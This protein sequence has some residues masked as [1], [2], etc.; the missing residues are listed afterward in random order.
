MAIQLVDTMPFIQHVAHSLDF[1]WIKY[2]SFLAKAIFHFY[3][4]Y[5]RENTHDSELTA[6][7]G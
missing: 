4:Y 1:K 6:D 7:L 5:Y 3:F 2:K